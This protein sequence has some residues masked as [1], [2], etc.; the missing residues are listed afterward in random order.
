VAAWYYFDINENARFMA[1]GND[2]ELLNADI[3]HV[4]RFLELEMQ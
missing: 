3:M 1:L 4:A 2:P